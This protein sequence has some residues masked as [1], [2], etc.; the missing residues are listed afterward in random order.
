MDWER[1]GALCGSHGGGGGGGGGGMVA[2]A[3]MV[4]AVAA[5]YGKY[6]VSFLATLPLYVCTVI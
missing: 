6:S 3:A 2:E 1:G 4:A 5:K